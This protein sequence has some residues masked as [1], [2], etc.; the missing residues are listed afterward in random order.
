MLKR[1]PCKH[2]DVLFSFN[3]PGIEMKVEVMLEIIAT[4]NSWP[5]QT[6]YCGL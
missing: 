5:L 4:N 3:L 1:L 6:F 2:V